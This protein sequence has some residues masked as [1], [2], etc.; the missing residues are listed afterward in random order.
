MAGE[1]RVQPHAAGLLADGVTLAT[2]EGD[3]A[4]RRVALGDLAVPSGRVV[5]CDPLA[6]PPRTTRPVTVPPGVYP[7]EVGVLDLPETGD[8][9]AWAMLCLADAPV[10]YWAAVPQARESAQPGKREPGISG[11]MDAE[12]AA[13]LGARLVDPATGPALRA[14]ILAAISAEAGDL[15]LDLPLD[16]EGRLNAILFTSGIGAG[17]YP[18]SAGYPDG[19]DPV[20]LLTDFLLVA[21]DGDE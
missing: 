8:R 2:D 10:A 1:E 21:V 3:I 16:E 13:L 15:W 18:T 11:F 6:V 5:A 7:V 19:P 9:I 20:C 17:V 12:A 14:E 4:V